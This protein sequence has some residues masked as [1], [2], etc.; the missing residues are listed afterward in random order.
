MTNLGLVRSDNNHQIIKIDPGDA[1]LISHG[2]EFV[3][4]LNEEYE[5]LLDTFSFPLVANNPKILGGNRHLLEF[6]DG[7]SSEKVTLALDKLNQLS[8]SLLS[9]IIQSPVYVDFLVQHDESEISYPAKVEQAQSFLGSI[10]N[11]LLERKKLLGNLVVNPSEQQWTTPIDQPKLVDIN[12]FTL[13]LHKIHAGNS[14][15]LV[16]RRKF[17]DESIGPILSEDLINF[18]PR[19][20]ASL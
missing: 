20:M 9:E 3:S 11:S 13:P 16:V 19:S 7:I 14:K 15:P 4:S 8:S 5:L 17:P 6:F 12:E 18:H 1:N 10:Y 2:D